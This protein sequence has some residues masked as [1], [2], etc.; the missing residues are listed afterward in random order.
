MCYIY[1]FCLVL[2]F[3][4]FKFQS[5]SFVWPC[6]CDCPTTARFGS[7]S[8]FYTK[9]WCFPGTALFCFFKKE[10]LA[11]SWFFGFRKIKLE[12][13]CSV[14][15]G[16]KMC[17]HETIL[18]CLMQRD[19]IWSNDCQTYISVFLWVQCDNKTNKQ[20][21][22]NFGL[23][24]VLYQHFPSIFVHAKPGSPDVLTCSWMRRNQMWPL[25][26]ATALCCTQPVGLQL[27]DVSFYSLYVC[28]Q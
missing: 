21:H 27:H 28:E 1:C 8:W 19:V 12:R 2:F 9:S 20:A 16:R 4:F 24:P 26:G 5:Q 25:D 11:K 13:W 23:S 3:F 22:V 15:P 7:S 17:R 18:T 14:C 6:W 10:I